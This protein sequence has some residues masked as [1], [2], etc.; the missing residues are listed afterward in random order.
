MHLKQLKLA[1]FKSFVEPTVIPFSSQLI[2]VVG[3]NGC[4]KSNI[5]DAVRWVM[6]EGS[7]KNLRGESM[8]DVIFNGSSTRK[9]VGQASVEL[10]FDNS[11]GRLT[12][13]YASY[14][15]IAVKRTVT[16]DGDSFYYLNGSRCRRRDITDIFLGTGASARGYSIIGQ[17]TIS[18]LVE[19]RP[20]ELRVYLEEAAGISKYKERRRETLQRIEKTRENLARVSDIREELAKQLSRLE[21]QAKAAEHYKTLKQSERLCKAE[22]LVL[23][24]QELLQE[25]NSVHQELAQLS[26]QYEAHQSKKVAS[27]KESVHLRETL[28]LE[29]DTLQQAQQKLYQ[30]NTEIARLEEAVQQQARELQ[31]LTAD[32]EQIEKDKQVTDRQLKAHQQNLLVSEE[33]LEDLQKKQE[34]LRE[35]LDEQQEILAAHEQQ[36][37]EHDILWQQMQTALH[38]AQR[39]V[40]IEQVNLQ[41]LEQRYQQT[42]LRLKKMDEEQSE[43]IIDNIE[44]ELSSLQIEHGQLAKAHEAKMRDYQTI[45]H[46]GIQL[47]EEQAEVEQQLYQAHDQV[48]SLIKEHAAMLAEQ[49]ATL[50]QS[51]NKE[52]PEAWKS[53]PRLAE[54]LEVP[55]QWLLACELVL[56][57]YL[58]TIV[59]ESTASLWPVLAEFKGQGI[60]FAQALNPPPHSASYPRLIDQVK[61]VFPCAPTAFEKIFAAQ[62]LTQALSWLPHLAN[63]QSIVTADGYW[64]GPGFIKAA[65]L[66]EEDQS[67]ILF[68]K[69]ALSALTKTLTIEQE[70]LAKLQVLRDQTHGSLNE[71]ERLL[72][73]LQEEVQISQDALIKIET[74]IQNKQQIIEHTLKRKAAIQEERSQLETMQAALFQEKSNTEKKWQTIAANEAL[75]KEKLREL[76]DIKTDW[77]GKVHATRALVDEAKAFL[78]RAE[79]QYNTEQLKVQQLRDNIEREERQLLMYAERLALLMT[80]YNELIS[81]SK[82]ETTSLN[83]KL[84]AH[85]QLNEK[86]IKQQE[87]VAHLQKELDEYDKVIKQEELQAQALQAKIQQEKLNEQRLNL[88]ADHFIEALNELDMKVEDVEPNLSDVS[89]PEKEQALAVLEEKIKRLGAIN[90]VAIEEYQMENARKAHLDEQYHDLTDALLTLEAAI[91]KMDK[92]TQLCLKDTFDQVNERFQVLFPRLFGGGRAML[93]LTCDNLLEAGVLIMAQPPGKRNSSI[94][95]LSGGEKAM[96]AVAF[97]FA[98]F[99]LNPSP[100]CMLDEVD[101]P[102]DDLNINR[103]CDLVREMSELVQFFFITHNKVTME[104]ADH[105]IGVTMREPGVSRIV[106]VDVDVALSMVEGS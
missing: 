86:A 53:K 9:S 98:I 73:A 83:D 94:H 42:A 33:A 97:V 49:H 87:A 93:Q 62:D 5:I 10:I 55:S 26:L 58:E 29:Q 24:R 70:N 78:H 61:G 35:V 81:P 22:I 39:E 72:A 74:A 38:D 13:Q 69:Q 37:S 66:K 64:V 2:A 104:L 89:L 75:Q 11:L 48:Q 18:R 28:Q 56:G 88:R 21:R 96:T 63:D 46:K 100:F 40:Q 92:E 19:A 44:A 54:T 90:L 7:A 43:L 76:K 8:T 103:F 51:S 3:P 82:L 71:N 105:L 67:G 52:L 4:G 106:A 57:E 17:D 99:Q 31:R 20:E 1:G 91:A 59:L 84:K 25:S 80:R 85:N 27:I 12:G 34:S 79:M 30:L 50:R 60:L 23:K 14:Q 77:D 36:K 15:E 68:R 102:L 101:A 45:R 41:H 16:R 47:R 6:G 95:L 32:K 65:N